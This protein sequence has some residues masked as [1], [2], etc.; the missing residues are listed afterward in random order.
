MVLVPDAG[1]MFTDHFVNSIIFLGHL[2]A[3]EQSIPT[4]R[5]SGKNAQRPV[6]MNKV[7]LAKLTCKKEAYRG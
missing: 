2:L 7:L 6:W 1:E 5:K 3:Q 4:D